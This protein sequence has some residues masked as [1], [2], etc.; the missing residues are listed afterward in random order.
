MQ[1]QH[2]MQACIYS[3]YVETKAKGTP[4]ESSVASFG[5]EKDG[6]TDTQGRHG[7][8]KH[9]PSLAAAAAAS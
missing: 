5:K 3:M 1:Q 9:R 4:A 8:A 6:P 7:E 2:T